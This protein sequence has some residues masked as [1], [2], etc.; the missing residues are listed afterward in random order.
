[1][2]ALGVRQKGSEQ[3]ALASHDAMTRDLSRPEIEIEFCKDDAILVGAF[4]RA[5]DVAGPSIQ[6]GTGGCA[7][8]VGPGTLHVMVALPTFDEDESVILNRMTRPLLRALKARYF[9]RDWIDVE[10]HPIAH[11]CFAHERAT[12]RTIFEAFI[13]VRTPFAIS[14]DR[15]SYLG[16][17]PAT[18]EALRGKL[19]DEALL[20]SIT[21]AYGMPIHEPPVLGSQPT[22]QGS[23]PWIAS[24]DEAIGPVHAGFDDT[25]RFRIG[26]EFMAS[27]DAVRDFEDR[28]ARGE[29]PEEAANSAFTAPH[30]A[31]FGVR[32]LETFAKLARLACAANP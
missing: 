2:S 6:R 5:C 28:I 3:I 16:K 27:F 4:Q 31:L 30:T 15:P 25:A 13:A 18:L 14:D 10:H 12:R 23:Q 1:M 19:D 7:V 29:A 32:S 21:D 26:G 9:G 20:K 22:A 17:N 11:V 24:V 8:R